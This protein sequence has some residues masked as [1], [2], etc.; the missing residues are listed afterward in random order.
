LETI[1]A[2]QFVGEDLNWWI[3][4]QLVLFGD[5][6]TAFNELVIRYL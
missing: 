1:N 3:D 4:N 2:K 6:E 5:L